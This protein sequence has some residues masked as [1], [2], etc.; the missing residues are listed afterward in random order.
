MYDMRARVLRE[1]AFSSTSI[2]QSVG[3]F[4]HLAK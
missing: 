4:L 2:A 3:P 1:K